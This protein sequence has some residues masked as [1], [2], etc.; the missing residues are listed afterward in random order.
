MDLNRTSLQIDVHVFQ[1]HLIPDVPLFG[2][3]LGHRPAR[4]VK[5]GLWD[6]DAVLPIFFDENTTP[7]NVLSITVP[8][9]SLIHISEPTRPY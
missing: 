9:L 6:L 1:F 7:F 4:Q 3:Y 5:F 8:N 2:R